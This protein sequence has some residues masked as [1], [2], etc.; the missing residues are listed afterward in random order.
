M[1]IKSYFAPSVQAAIKLA[2]KEFGEG[3]TLVTS[4]VASIDTRDLGEYEVVFA[5]EEVSEQVEQQ[6]VSEPVAPELI[7]SEPVASEP[8]IPP[9]NVFQDL[10]QKAIETKP[11][12]RENL[13]EKLAQLRVAFI[14]IG[15]ESTMV[16]ALMTMVESCVSSSTPAPAPLRVENVAAPE[17]IAVV[18][19]QKTSV[20]CSKSVEQH[21]DLHASSHVDQHVDQHRLSA[22]EL[23]FV[24]AVSGGQ[25]ASTVNHSRDGAW[26]A[27]A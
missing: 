22:A 3:V 4:H 21:V 15:L 8:V 7:A 19:E 27:K 23:A 6:V 18:E 24:L 9:P 5:I 12:T 16:R 20:P 26:S 10:L 13:P 2:R 11:S 25:E 1:R 14:E 17:C